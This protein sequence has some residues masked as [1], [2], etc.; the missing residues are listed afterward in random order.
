M[1]APHLASLLLH[2]RR[3]AEPAAGNERSDGELLE[4][5]AHGRDEAAFELLL[6]RH[7]A[8]VH[9]LCRSIL[10]DPHAADDALQATF[11]VLARKAASIRKHHSVA[12]WL[13]GVAYRIALRAKSQTVRR[14]LYERQVPTMPS[15]EAMADLGRQELQELL[16]EELQGLPEKYRAPLVLC[17]LEGKSN[18]GAALALGWP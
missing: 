1:A 7:G 9:N 10:R 4:R 3:L 2:I 18:D 12:S 14:R 15:S 13:Y 5:F 8:M 16:H 11:L 17:Y 6:H